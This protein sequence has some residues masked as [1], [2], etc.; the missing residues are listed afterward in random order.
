MGPIFKRYLHGT[1]VAVAPF[2]LDR[3]L[4][5]Q[6]FRYNK[7]KG[8]DKTRFMEAMLSVVGKRLTFK[9]LTGGA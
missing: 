4:D 7:R 6:T 9:E 1:Y 5:E 3:Y 8:T 2:H